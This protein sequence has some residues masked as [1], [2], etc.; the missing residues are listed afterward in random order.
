MAGCPG[1]LPAVY[2]QM[3]PLALALRS[4][5]VRTGDRALA[6]RGLHEWQDPWVHSSEKRLDHKGWGKSREKASL[7]DSFPPSLFLVGVVQVG[8]LRG[9]RG[10]FLPGIGPVGLCVVSSVTTGVAGAVS[11]VLALALAPVSIEPVGIVSGILGAALFSVR[12]VGAASHVLAWPPVDA[13]P[14]GAV[15]SV[16]GCFWSM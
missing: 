2:K 5:Q 14:G 13:G 3:L 12:P 15:S 10:L 8:A 1:G 6:L 9:A 7:K 16:Q 4:D 11:S